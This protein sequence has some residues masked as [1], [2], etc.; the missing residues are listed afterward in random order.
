VCSNGPFVESLID[1]MIEVS[2]NVFGNDSSMEP[3]V[4]LI[5]GRIRDDV[6]GPTFFVSG[7]DITLN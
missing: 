6:S 4:D 1:E 5:V 3:N 2:S 7:I